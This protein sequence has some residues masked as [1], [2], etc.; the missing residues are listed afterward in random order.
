MI[1]TRVMDI[2][3]RETAEGL[4]EDSTGKALL[5]LLW[6]G[7]LLCCGAGRG[8]DRGRPLGL[9]MKSGGSVPS[10][11]R[12]PQALHTV[13]GGTCTLF[14]AARGT[15]PLLLCQAQGPFSSFSSFL[16][17]TMSPCLV[18]MNAKEEVL[19][20]FIHHLRISKGV[21]RR[22]SRVPGSL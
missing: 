15:F 17:V 5:P 21:R 22:L 13:T 4:G 8:A 12:Y 2:K 3:L 9:C 16:E 6:G 18:D 10:V 20:G 19:N 14:K 1:S 7:H 11:L